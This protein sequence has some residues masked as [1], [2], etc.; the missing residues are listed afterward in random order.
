MARSLLLAAFALLAAFS[1]AHA[2]EPLPPRG[3]AALLHVRFLGA[4]GMR[5]TLYRDP[6][7]PRNSISP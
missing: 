2:Q 6:S 5:L 3:P 1:L 7:G 4:P